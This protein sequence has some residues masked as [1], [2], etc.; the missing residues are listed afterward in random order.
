MFSTYNDVLENIFFLLSAFRG[1]KGKTSRALMGNYYSSS[2]VESSFQLSQNCQL[3]CG[4]T[5]SFVSVFYSPPTLFYSCWWK[6]FEDFFWR[7]SL[8]DSFFTV[9]SKLYPKI[10]FQILFTNF[11]F[12]VGKRWLSSISQ[13]LNPFKWSHSLASVDESTRFFA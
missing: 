13:I 2:D 10:L 11:S 7:C 1:R 12:S 8:L 6:F 4:H 9:L 5:F 3:M